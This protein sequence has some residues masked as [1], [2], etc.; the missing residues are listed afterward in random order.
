VL[1]LRS[2]FRVQTRYMKCDCLYSF[3]LSATLVLWIL[4]N[5]NANLRP[6]P[7]S[8]GY[9]GRRLNSNDSGNS[10]SCASAYPMRAC[11][12]NQVELIG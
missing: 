12:E 5:S 1:R 9:N 6:N 11:L 7:G 4:W 8:L 2:I 3:Y 10:E